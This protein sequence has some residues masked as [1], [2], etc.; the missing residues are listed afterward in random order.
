LLQVP[1]A[2]LFGLGVGFMA[3]FPFGTGVS[4]TAIGLL[5]ALKNFWLGMKVLA[6]A[7]IIQQVIENGVAPRLLGGFTGLNPVWILVALLLGAQV[8]GILGLLLAVPLAGF[9]KGAAMVL[10]S[11]L[12]GNGYSQ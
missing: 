2:L 8:A 6:V 9:L 1:F 11:H 12:I 7:A 3:L 10:R 5:M 4:I